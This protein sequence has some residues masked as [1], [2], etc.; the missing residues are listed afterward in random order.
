MQT[1]RCSKCHTDKDA[2]QFSPWNRGKDGLASWCKSCNRDYQRRRRQE[3]AIIISKAT[4][5][6]AEFVPNILSISI[7]SDL[8]VRVANIP[9]DLTRE[10]ANRIERIVKAFADD[11]PTGGERT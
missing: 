8:T 9:T 5:Q 11:D 4:P 1:K 10:E 3:R 6:A 2:T 7:R